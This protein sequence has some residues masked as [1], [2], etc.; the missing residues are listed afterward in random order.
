[1]I[2]P[3]ELPEDIDNK[4]E[5]E[6]FNRFKE[7]EAAYDIFYSRKFEKKA[8]GE[9]KQKQYE[10]DFIIAKQNNGIICLEVKGGIIRYDG[11]SSKWYQNNRLCSPQPDD[12]VK[13]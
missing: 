2:Y 6:V 10:V 12:Q 9:Q 11:N 3:G 4:G 8:S 13:S 7:I 1:M 5:I